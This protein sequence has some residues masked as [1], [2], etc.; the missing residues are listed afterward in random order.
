MTKQYPSTFNNWIKETCGEVK[1]LEKKDLGEDYKSEYV[2]KYNYLR[3]RGWR[4][5]NNKWISPHPP[6][7]KYKDIAMAYASQNYI[8][9]I[10]ER[11]YE[12][13]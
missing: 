8:E 6:H 7:R 2:V 13:G 9:N 1:R 12:R 3:D 5:E 11:K 4:R 10:L